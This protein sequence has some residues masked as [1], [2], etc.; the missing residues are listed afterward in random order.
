M[1]LFNRFVKLSL[2]ASYKGRFP[3]IEVNFNNIPHL[4][5]LTIVFL[6]FCL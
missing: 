6:S 3:N 2:V 1:N 5:Y 4:K